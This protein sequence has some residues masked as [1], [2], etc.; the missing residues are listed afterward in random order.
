V[1]VIT[2][3]AVQVTLAYKNPRY[4]T[5]VFKQSGRPQSGDN[6]WDGRC[7]RV[8]LILNTILFEEN[9]LNAV[10]LKRKNARNNCNV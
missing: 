6:P 2:E 1:C 3:P 9:K 10:K 5:A 7:K 4:I 8:S